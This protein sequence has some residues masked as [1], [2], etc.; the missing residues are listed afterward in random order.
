M[1]EEKLRRQMQKLMIYVF[2]FVIVFVICGGAVLVY[3]HNTNNKNIKEQV[4]VEAG[5]YKTRILKQFEKDFQTLSTL[6]AFIDPH[7]IS[8][9]ALLAERLEQANRDNNFLT[10]VYFGQDGRGVISTTGN[11]TVTG[12]GFSELSQEGMKVVK[13]ALA[14][15]AS[16]SRLF[17]SE[18]SGQRV[19]AYAVPVYDGDEIV[20]ALAASDHIAIFSD[21]VSGNT[22][23]GGG[24]YI[25]ILDSEGDFLVRSSKTVVQEELSSIFDGP[26][27]SESSSEEVKNA[28]QRQERIF[29]SFTYDGETYPFL[30]EPVDINGWYIFC[31]DTGEGLSAN[32]SVSIM[33]VQITFFGILLL[34]IFMMFRGYRLLRN[35]NRDLISMAYFDSLTGAENMSRFRQRLE[36][37]I[38]NGEGS[39]AAISIRQYIFLNEIF[40]KE[41]TNQLLCQI[42]EAADRHIGKGEFFCRD[43]DDRFFLFL[44]ETDRKILRTRLEAFM[45]EIVQNAEISRTDYQLA[46]Y[47]GVAVS[48]DGG[49]PE[50]TAD[51]LMESVPF[52]LERAKGSHSNNIWFFDTELHKIE[53]L[54]NYIESHMHQ[55]LRDGE[56]K[57]FLQPQKNLKT[58]MLG[59]AEALVRWQT[60]GGKS[61]FP[62]RFIPM[63][64]RNGFCV[65]LDRYMLEQVF[66]QIRSWTDRGIKPIPVSVNQS[67]LLFFEPDYVQTLTELVRKYN[68]PANLITLEILEGLALENADE[69]NIKI[70]QL[71]SLGFR[72]SL[73][74]F[75]SGYSSLN[76]LGKLKIDELK[77]D[78]DFLLSASDSKQ[79]RVKLIM[80]Q[81]VRLAGQLGIST[82]AE[83]VET[84]E[85]EEFIKSIGCDVGQGYL[86]DRPVSAADF[87]KKYMQSADGNYRFN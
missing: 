60:E 65:N 61:I 84:T 36:K 24:G 54:E 57:L 39:V 1:I 75:G 71:Q 22:V 70:D 5:E 32:S 55:A 63:F 69:L 37:A 38:G 29:S 49:S 85:D 40:G 73:D 28:M 77:L 66:R 45:D 20:G 25:H 68:V 26:Y 4:I 8:D 13:K 74:D 6:S 2:C 27:L 44:K 56:F 3:L 31:V 34:V 86:Y 72:I 62:D 15:T 53:E 12:A 16:V 76:T 43:T 48:S 58:G 52:A 41:K 33:V 17:E 30:L 80:E 67:K 21:I 42:K 82:V 83:G 50:K 79:G 10:M 23:L 87:D 47:C 64:E 46:I 19:F 35:Y 9:E 7:Y 11:E 14:G 51:N 59:S 81:T 18:F 78:R